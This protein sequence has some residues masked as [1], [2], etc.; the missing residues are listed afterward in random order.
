MVNLDIRQR[1]TSLAAPTV[2]LQDFLAEC[3]VWFRVFQLL[4]D[5][6]GESV[7]IVSS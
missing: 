6:I 2:S 1:S 4:S 7:V 3:S 5:N